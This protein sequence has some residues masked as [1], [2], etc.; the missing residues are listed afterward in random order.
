MARKKAPSPGPLAISKEITVTLDEAALLERYHDLTK[1]LDKED[2][3]LLNA[4]SVKGELNRQTK[5]I[6]D[7]IAN[8]RDAIKTCKE[9]RVVMVIPTPN[10]SRWEMDYRDADTGEIYP[11][12]SRDFTPEERAKFSQVALI[13]DGADGS[14]A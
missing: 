14:E 1:L 5:E 9:D 8:V 4:A 3:H 10:K 2:G 6:R 11:S 13:T 7:E 12:I